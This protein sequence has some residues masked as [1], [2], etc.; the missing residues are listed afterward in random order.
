MLLQTLIGRF[1]YQAEHCSFKV[2]HWLGMYCSTLVAHYS[3]SKVS[4]KLLDVQDLSGFHGIDRSI[5]QQCAMY[6]ILFQTLKLEAATFTI[7]LQLQENFVCQK[8]LTYVRTPVNCL[9]CMACLGFA[10]T[11]H[12]EPLYG[13][14]QI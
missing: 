5:T 4:H 13:S 6:F 2:M 14:N 7:V 9:Q 8:M 1:S 10:C 11:P 3:K 12:T